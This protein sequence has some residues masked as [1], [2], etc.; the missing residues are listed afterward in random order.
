MIAVLRAAIVAI[1]VALLSGLTSHVADAAT[2]ASPDMQSYAYDGRHHTAP[3]TFTTSERGPPAA[4][5]ALTRHTAVD[6][7]P[8]GELAH[9]QP[10]V[11]GSYAEYDHSAQLAPSDRASVTT[12]TA[13]GG[14]T[15]HLRAHLDVRCAAKTAPGIKAGAEGGE[16]AG[17]THPRSTT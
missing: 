17:K 7:R 8:H 9:P 6:P 3:P 10:V 2:P 16:T 11:S 15:A 14:R 4:E 13:P 12:R 5:V 1:L